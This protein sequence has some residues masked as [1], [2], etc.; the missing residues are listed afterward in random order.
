MRI[1]LTETP[2]ICC[3]P[4]TLNWNLNLTKIKVIKQFNKNEAEAEASAYVKNKHFGPIHAIPIE[5]LFA[6]AKR[7]GGRFLI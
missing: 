5:N 6:L 2:F 3:I 7:P 1:P 4:R